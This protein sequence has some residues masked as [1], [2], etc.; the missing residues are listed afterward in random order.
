MTLLRDIRLAFRL[1]LRAPL[2]AGIALLSIALSVGASAVVFAAIKAVLLDP[3]PY[4]NPAGLVQLRSEYSKA[5]FNGDWVVWNDASA[6]LATEADF[7]RNRFA[8]E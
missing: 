2:P 7:L 1:F 6:S 8:P 4:T 3:L 5:D